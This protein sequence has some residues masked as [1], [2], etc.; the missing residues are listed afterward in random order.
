MKYYCKH[1]GKTVEQNSNKKWID[2]WCDQTDKR[3][4]LIIKQSTKKRTLKGKKHEKEK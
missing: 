3:T 1:C 4:R 2:S